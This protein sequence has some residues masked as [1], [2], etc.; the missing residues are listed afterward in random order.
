MTG[1]QRAGGVAALFEAATF[2]VGLA[3]FV[4]ILEP[5]RY[6]SSAIEPA[7][8][9]AFMAANLSLLQALNFLVY[10][11]F[12]GVLVV[13]VVALHDR[14]KSGAPALA[15]IGAAF[16]LIWAGLVIAS[17]MVANIGL[18][19]IAALAARQ[20]EQAVLVW[21]SYRFVVNGLGGGNEIVGGLWLLITSLAGLAGGLPRRLNHAGIVVAASGLLTTI[22]AFEPLGMVF[23]LGLIAW[24][25]ACGVVLLRPVRP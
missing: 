9:V 7:R 17:G 19:T 3:V 20:P 10:V 6:G 25:A 18:G 24:F 11:A 8:H 15:A 14:L 13:L 22:P 1:L 23:G 5:A 12:G 16:G 4:V 2:I 21:Q